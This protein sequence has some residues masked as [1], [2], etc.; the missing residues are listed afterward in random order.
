MNCQFGFQF[1]PPVTPR[2]AFAALLVFLLC[3]LSLFCVAIYYV[4]ISYFVLLSAISYCTA[5]L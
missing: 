4:V 2:F 3:R 1:K 5:V